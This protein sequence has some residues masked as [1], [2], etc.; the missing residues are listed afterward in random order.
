MRLRILVLAVL[1]AVP[2]A[3]LTT[4]PASAAGTGCNTYAS[5]E[6]C[7]VVNADADW[8]FGYVQLFSGDSFEYASIYV[9]QCRTDHTH[10]VTLAANNKPLYPYYIQTSQKPAA[11]GHAFRTRGTW[12]TKQGWHYVAVWSPWRTNP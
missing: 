5:A 10:C 2:L 7:V 8:V 1:L 9:E 6:I 12:R 11:Y 4:V 3:G